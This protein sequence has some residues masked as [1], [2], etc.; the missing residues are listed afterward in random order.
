MDFAC[1]SSL[2]ADIMERVTHSPAIVFEHYESFKMTY[3]DTANKCEE[4]GFKFTPMILDAHSGGWSHTARKVLSR[5]AQGVAS[6]WGESRDAA[7]LKIAQRISISLHRENVRAVL[8][9]LVVQAPEAPASSGWAE[10]Q[11]EDLWQ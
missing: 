1:T 4:Q 10:N 6:C 3:K 11:L 7:S 8:K 2:R 9:R 5:V